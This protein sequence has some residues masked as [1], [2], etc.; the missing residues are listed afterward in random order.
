M[1]AATLSQTV[2][3]QRKAVPTFKMLFSLADF[4]P[5]R[6]RLSLLITRRSLR[7]LA[8]TTAK[9]INPGLSM[10]RSLLKSTGT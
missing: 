6:A 8:S 4:P 9:Q 3:N 7:Q 1:P 10:D 2:Y 5:E